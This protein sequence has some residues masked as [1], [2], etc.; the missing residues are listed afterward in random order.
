MPGSAGFMGPEVGSLACYPTGLFSRRTLVELHLV[1]GQ[2]GQHW[3]NPKDMRSVLLDCCETELCSQSPGLKDSKQRQHP[4]S[5]PNKHFVMK[6]QS[7]PVVHKC[8][9]WTC[10]RL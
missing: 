4:A 2:T 8:G 1:W 5:S 7:L 10:A 6:N 3:R 9:V